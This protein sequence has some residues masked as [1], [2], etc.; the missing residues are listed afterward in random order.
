MVTSSP[1]ILARTGASSHVQT[2]Q[3]LPVTLP[4]E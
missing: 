1:E 2:V 3:T 4:L